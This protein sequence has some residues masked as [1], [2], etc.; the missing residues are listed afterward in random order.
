MINIIIFMLCLA[1]M[2]NI[3]SYNTFW[4]YF[5][6]L[7]LKTGN[8]I[9]NHLAF[10]FDNDSWQN[11]YQLKEY[12][13]SCDI[14][15]PIANWLAKDILVVITD[16]WHFFKA[17]GIIAILQ[18]Y[19]GEFSEVLKLYRIN[20]FFTYV[21]TFALSGALFNYLFYSFSKLDKK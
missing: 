5:T 12:L 4:N 6:R 20:Y 11:K 21:I 10:W 7:Y 16:A 9:Y 18:P 13:I 19:V 1:V 8:K 2:D 15:A 3:S 14:P 17:V